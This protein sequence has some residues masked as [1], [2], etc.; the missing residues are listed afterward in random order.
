MIGG[1]LYLPATRLD[2]VDIANGT[3]HASARSMVFCT[4]DAIRAEELGA[5]L[6]NLRL[7][8]PAVTPRPALRFARPRSPQVLAHILAIPGVENLDG[9]VLPKVN[10]VRFGQFLEVLDGHERFLLMPTLET[11]ETF[12]PAEMRALRRMLEHET[13]RPRI[14]SLRIGANDLLQLLGVRR[15]S[16]TTIYE[17]GLRSVIDMLA[18]VFK[19]HGFNLTAPVFEG[20][21]H[22]EVLASEVEQDLA[23]GLFGKTA[24][25]PG[26][27]AVI[28]AAYSVS[29]DDL[30]M[31]RMVLHPEQPAVFR[32]HDIMCERT[33]HAAWAEL[34]VARSRIYGVR[35][36]EAT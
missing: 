7:V 14:L 13:I 27:L 25:H 33:T 17:T 6:E 26:Q 3:R 5:A 23:H 30:E 31:A 20:L 28:E 4:E 2:L 35:G 21:A 16:T 15:S 12:D 19:P 8:L 10:C 32:M 29:A 24:I 11:A 36:A 34:I 22:P 1:T 18:G 9:F